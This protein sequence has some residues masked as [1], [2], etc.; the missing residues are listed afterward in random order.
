MKKFTSVL[1]LYVDALFKKVMTVT[2][3]MVSSELLFTF[4]VC[5]GLAGSIKIGTGLMEFVIE[6]FEFHAFAICFIIL[7]NMLCRN[8]LTSK[9]K[10][11]YTLERLSV[12]GRGLYWI[13][14]LCNLLYLSLF[15]VFRSLSVIG[16]VYIKDCYGKAYTG[17]Q[18]KYLEVISTASENFGL[19]LNNTTMWIAIVFIIVVMGLITGGIS[20]SRRIAQTEEKDVWGTE[21]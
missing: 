6:G 14:V 2:M 19:P 7:I 12:S 13:N 10:G 3:I 21:L 18:G 15:W 20:N 4:V 8:P 1:S 5:S 16:Q 11:N 17:P 9:G